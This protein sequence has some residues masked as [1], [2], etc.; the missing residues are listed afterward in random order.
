MYLFRKTTQFFLEGIFHPLEWN[1]CRDLPVPLVLIFEA[2]SNH[3]SFLLIWFPY[4]TSRR[5]AQVGKNENAKWK[6]RIVLIANQHPGLCTSLLNFSE[7][8]SWI[9]SILGALTRISESKKLSPESTL[10]WLEPSPAACQ[11]GFSGCH[12]IFISPPTMA[13]TCIH[14]ISSL[15]QLLY[16]PL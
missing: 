11:S 4:S 15:Y 14:F 5:C 6:T 2:S 1:A 8:V 12:D 9:W 10:R 13:G 7:S 3:H 16:W